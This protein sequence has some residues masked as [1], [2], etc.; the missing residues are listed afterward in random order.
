MAIDCTQLHLVQPFTHGKIIALET[1]P[2][3]SYL[4]C[5]STH[6]M[7][8]FFMEPVKVMYH[9]L[10]TYLIRTVVTPSVK[11]IK[12]FDDNYTTQCGNITNILMTVLHT[13]L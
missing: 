13:L 7:I 11:G 12:I 1:M 4:V 6:R 10:R 2:Y 9:T 5:S 8:I 3:Y